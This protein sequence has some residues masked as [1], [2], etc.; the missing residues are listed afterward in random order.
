MMQYCM[1]MRQVLDPQ[2]A[3]FACLQAGGGNRSAML[4][5]MTVRSLPCQCHE[6]LLALLR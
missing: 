5:R 2:N 3:H 6:P 1:A 4:D